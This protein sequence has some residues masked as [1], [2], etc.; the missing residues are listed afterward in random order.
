MSQYDYEDVK[1][2]INI[3]LSQINN[4][5]GDTSLGKGQSEKK[6]IKFRQEEFFSVDPDW[7]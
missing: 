2:Q 4:K 3:K 5:K 1:N 6:E 7:K